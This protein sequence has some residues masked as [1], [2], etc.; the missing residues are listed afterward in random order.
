[1]NRSPL[2]S[3]A[4]GVVAI[5]A[6]S[7]LALT[8]AGWCAGQDPATNIGLIEIDDAPRERP[9][10]LAD[11]FGGKGGQTLRT[12][13]EAI[14][15]A[16]DD[17]DLDGLVIRLRDAELSTTQVEE[18]GAAMD[19]VRG[20]G[21]KVH[22]FADVYS[23]PELL[24]GAHADEVIV[25]SGG[26]VSFPGLY[27]EEM[28]LADTLGWVGIQ[29]DFVQ[30]GDYK[31]ASEPMARSGPSP[32]WEQNISQLLDGLYAN[33]RAGIRSGRKLSDEQLDTAMQKAV[34]A[35]G[36]T[37]KEV[38]LVDALVDLPD[39]DKHLAEAYGGKIEWTN[40]TEPEPPTGALDLSSPLALLRKLLHA[41]SHAPTRDSLAVLHI[42]GPIVDGESGGGFMGGSEVGSHTIR[43]A[44]QEIEDEPRIKGV[45]VRIDS[46]GGSAMASEVIWQGL[47]R[48]GKTRPVWV[49]VGSMAA[50]G[51]YYIAAAGEQVYVNPS[52][53]VGSIGVVGGKLAMGGLYDKIKLHVIARS[54]GP[55]GDVLGSAH[56]WS[57]R[58]RTLIRQKMTETYDLFTRR[59]T[60]GRKGIDLAATAEGR[61]FTG[62]TAITN[63]MADKIGGLDEA[64]SD[65]AEKAGLGDGAFDVLDYPAPETLADLLGGVL[66]S[67][68]LAPSQDDNTA[69][70]PAYAA[71]GVL[72]EVVGHRAWPSVRDNLA[73]LWQLRKERVL[74]VAPRIL[75]FR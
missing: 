74:L 17:D 42:D 51:G 30:I 36:Q 16:A 72:R 65:L 62:N 24:L 29:P 63:R 8:P 44:I 61:L 14:L 6:A 40:L 70:A 9:A 5:C 10:P 26:E 55:M 38:G 1:M 69:N 48:L 67:M 41:P 49:S 34:M 15:S 18:L 32:Q 56:P 59:V 13:T 64:V 54:R 66:G 3:L 75:I 4:A 68:A 50:S 47:Q 52:S 28:Y 58:E 31:G 71:L 11:L 22:L 46:P 12:L 53:I 2:A 57:D 7:A 73:A 39:L 25:Q 23:T 20:S 35:S 33:I 27:T 60:A 37:G 43:R 19:A 45:I 21:K